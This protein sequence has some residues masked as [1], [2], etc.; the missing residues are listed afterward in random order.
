[1]CQCL[2]FVYIY[3]KLSSYLSGTLYMSEGDRKELHMKG[4]IVEAI[5]YGLYE[6]EYTEWYSGTIHQTRSDARI[7]LIDAQ[8]DHNYDSYRIVCVER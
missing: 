7:E 4:Y 1:M 6:E 2:Q 8:N 3:A 5:W